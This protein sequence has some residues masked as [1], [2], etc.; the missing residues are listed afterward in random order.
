[1][2]DKGRKNVKKPKQIKDKN[3]HPRDYVEE[4]G[5]DMPR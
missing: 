1:M 2:G 5:L 3:K 4:L